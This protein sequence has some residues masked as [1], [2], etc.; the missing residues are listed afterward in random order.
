MKSYAQLFFSI[1]KIAINEDE[2]YIIFSNLWCECKH[3]QSFLTSKLFV[4]FSVFN[5]INPNSISERL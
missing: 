4:D 2:P 3:F 1:P 5:G